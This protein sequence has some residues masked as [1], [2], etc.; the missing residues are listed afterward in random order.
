V[1]EGQALRC[2]CGYTF[3]QDLELTIAQ[4][5]DQI[6]KGKNYALG[7]ALCLGLGALLLVLSIMSGG[8]V[9]IAFLPWIFGFIYLP[10]ALRLLRARDSKASLEKLRELPAARVIDP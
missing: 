1:N 3:G 7:A 10:H 9:F 5:D 8:P 4:L 2:G 6:R